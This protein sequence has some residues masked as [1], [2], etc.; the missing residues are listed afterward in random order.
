MF[1][2]IA[3]VHGT[4]AFADRGPIVP[5]DLED[6]AVRVD[7]F[8]SRF[9][10]HVKPT[11]MQ[12]FQQWKSRLGAYAGRYQE[13]LVRQSFGSE[14]RAEAR[15]KAAR[16]ELNNLL[17]E[18]FSR[19]EKNQSEADA[20]CRNAVATMLDESQDEEVRRVVDGYANQ[21]RKAK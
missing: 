20:Y 7:A 3:W 18:Y 4:S 15:V 14:G 16:D 12:A 5:V 8:C 10:P 17:S 6:T 2:A 9:A 1:I 19:L 21:S 11:Y 13:Y